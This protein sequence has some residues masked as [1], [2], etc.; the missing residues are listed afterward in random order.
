[1]KMCSRNRC[2]TALIVSVTTR[3]KWVVITGTSWMGPVASLYT[4]GPENL[5]FL[6]QISPD[7]T[8]YIL[9]PLLIIFT[10][11]LECKL[12]G[13]RYVQTQLSVS[14][15]LVL[16]H[17]LATVG[18]PQVTKMYN[19]EKLYS[20]RSLVVVHILNFQDLFMWFIHVVL[21]IISI[22]V[23]PNFQLDLVMQFIHIELIII[24]III[25]Y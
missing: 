10:Q 11:I 15:L 20:V 18:H 5:T 19:E 12:W 22:I 8:V 1:M 24:I 17:V 14:V 25:S 23:I 16:R 13:D 9:V 4:E 6:P 3:W 21:I 2:I 7:H